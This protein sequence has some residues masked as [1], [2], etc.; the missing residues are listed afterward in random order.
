MKKN[1]L[2]LDMV[3][4][5]HGV[6]NKDV[7]GGLGTRTQIGNSWRAK[8]L[9]RAKKKGIVLPLIEFAYLAALLRDQGHQV[10][11]KVL[12]TRS[13]NLENIV[14]DTVCDCII[15]HPS[16]VSFKDEIK[17]AHRIKELFPKIELGAIGPFATTFPDQLTE[18]FDWIVAGECDSFFSENKLDR[19]D[20]INRTN[21]YIQDLDKLPFPNWKVFSEHNYSY[22]PILKRTPFYTMQASRG[23]P[24]SCKYYCPYPAFQGDKWRTRSIP[25]LIEEISYLHKD[26]SAKSILFRDPFFSI[27]KKRSFEFGE[28]LIRSGLEIQWACETRIDSLDKTLIDVLHRSGLRAINVG[29]ES[30][31]DNILKANKRK[32]II[33]SHQNEIIDYCYKKG[34]KLNAFFILGLQGDTFESINK[35]I[36][37]ACSQKL[38]SAQFTINT[39]LPGTQFYS[40]SKAEIND[41]NLEHFDNN[42]LVFNHP[43][44][45]PEEINHVKEKAFLKYYFRPQFLLEQIRWNFLRN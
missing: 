31:D 28:A 2:I 38:F 36:K 30:E 10:S 1:V 21:Q 25:S 37:Y 23:C 44:F 22:R 20:K 4:S 29:I 35:T 3:N 5:S 11:Y 12:D 9:E 15:F 34:I 17:I 43:N 16:L 24:M 40:D 7:N 45:T 27:N 14:K 8:I 39:P 33:K 32:G 19:L 13:Q 18:S 42:T 6:V 26:F 41:D